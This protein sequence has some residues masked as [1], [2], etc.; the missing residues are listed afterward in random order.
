MNKSAHRP[1]VNEEYLVSRSLP[2]DLTGCTQQEFAQ[3]LSELDQIIGL[4]AL[5]FDAESE[6]LQLNYDATHVD[7]DQLQS[8]L[9]QH[10]VQLKP[11]LINR[12]KSGYYEFV[13]ENI[14]ANAEHQ[15]QC[16]HSLGASPVNKKH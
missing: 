11:G 10:N 3:L 15:P 4:D 2:L 5:S 6:I 8:C 1:G 9:Q 7:F 14:K 12:L 13:D 16:C